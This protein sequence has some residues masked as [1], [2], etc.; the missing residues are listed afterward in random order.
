[1]I[2]VIYSCWINIF[3]SQQSIDAITDDMY[4]FSE[5]VDALP[6]MTVHKGPLMVVLIWLEAGSK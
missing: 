5:T 6:T 1:M 3:I 4:E 2:T